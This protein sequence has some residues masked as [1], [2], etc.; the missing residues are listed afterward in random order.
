MLTH[1]ILY[2]LGQLDDSKITIVKQFL[3]DRVNDENEN[4]LARHESAEA[5]AN[6]FLPEL[7]ELY[8]KHL[9]S[10]CKELRWTCEIANQKIKF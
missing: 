1:E 6:Y 5:L 3:I 10:S 9:T 2:A 7:S 8:K 4:N